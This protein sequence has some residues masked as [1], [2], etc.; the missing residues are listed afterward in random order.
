[1]T[2]KGATTLTGPAE[3]LMEILRDEHSPVGG[4]GSPLPSG[5]EI[6]TAWVQL[7][8]RVRATLPE[9][10]TAA[11]NAAIASLRG[12]LSRLQRQRLDGSYIEWVRVTDVERALD[13][14]EAAVQR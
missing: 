10:D 3:R 1:M 7:K 9:I 8:H 2:A 5:Q 11:C 13:E 6:A 4:V 14:I 12:R